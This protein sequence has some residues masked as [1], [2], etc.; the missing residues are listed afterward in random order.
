MPAPLL[1]ALKRSVCD[2]NPVGPVSAR[3]PAERAHLV[4]IGDA[5][6]DQIIHAGHDVFITRGEV[7]A[8]DVVAMLLAVVGRAAIVGTQ[9]DVAGA[10]V[11]LRAVLRH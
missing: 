10:G 1:I 11:D 6:R 2:E 4:R 8:D 7:V 3:A 9:H 5:L